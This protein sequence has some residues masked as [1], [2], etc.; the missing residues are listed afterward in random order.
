MRAVFPSGPLVPEPTAHPL[1]SPFATES[2]RPLE[3]AHPGSQK[4]TVPSKSP[5]HPRQTTPPIPVEHR[6]P[7]LDG[8]VRGHPVDHPLPA[9]LLAEST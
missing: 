5:H 6:V 1:H 4:P 7:R 2:H 3:E 8:H 9:E